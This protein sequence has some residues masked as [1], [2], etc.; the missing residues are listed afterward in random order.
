MINC[1]RQRFSDHLRN[2]THATDSKAC[3]HRV[4]LK[5]GVKSL[6][7][8]NAVQDVSKSPLVAL[9]VFVVLTIISKHLNVFRPD[10]TALL[11]LLVALLESVV[12]GQGWNV[13]L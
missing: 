8:G 2:K 6:E 3:I 13:R 5:S 1:S 12:C 9:W 7:E 11:R 10:I 4:K